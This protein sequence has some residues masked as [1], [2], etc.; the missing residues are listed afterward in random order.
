[1][2]FISAAGQEK[3]N[4]SCAV[5][6]KKTAFTGLVPAPLAAL[7]SRESQ[8][9]DETLEVGAFNDPLY[10]TWPIDDLS[11]DIY[12]LDHDS[13]YDVLAALFQTL[14]AS[15]TANH[16]ITEAA[17]DGWE[18]GLADLG[19]FD[20]HIDAPGRKIFLHN[21]GLSAAG[22]MRSPYFKNDLLIALL[23]AL[24]DVAH[25]K[26]QGGFDERFGPDDILKLERVRAA[27]CD[28]MTVLCAWELRE[29]GVNSLWRHILALGEGDLA[30]TF[31]DTLEREKL[32]YPVHKAL[33]AAFDQ[34][35]RDTKRVNACDHE[36]LEYIDQVLMTFP[37]GDAFGHQAVC[38]RDIESLSCLPDRTAYLH[39]AGE[40]I[41]KAPLYA[42]LH[43][44]VNQ[45]HY[46]QVLHDAQAITVQGVPFRDAALAARIF[47]GGEM[48][49]EKDSLPV[50]DA[51]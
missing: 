19:G 6:T 37:A 24:R 30:L 51:R 48:T 26:R 25:E 27:D 46:M 41:L 12:A 43:D 34:W 14:T 21:K 10:D 13:E 44:P 5:T 28:V 45:S 33:K 22:L 49:P 15:P 9:L 11:V 40:S 20:F 36:T 47:P 38:A 4:G 50:Q 7:Y 17:H 18:A 2:S 29:T 32:A 35:Y 23:R 31:Q 39:N 1:M 42:G 8:S 16:M 3:L